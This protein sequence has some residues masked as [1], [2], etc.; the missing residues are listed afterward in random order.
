VRPS[1]L[2]LCQWGI[3]AKLYARVQSEFIC[4]LKVGH[5]QPSG[6]VEC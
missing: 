5:V 6:Y 3:I 1:E 4:N 2:R